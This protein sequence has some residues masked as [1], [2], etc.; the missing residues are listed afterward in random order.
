MTTETAEDARPP[1]SRII[2]AVPGH[3]TPADTPELLKDDKS[4]QPPEKLALIIDYMAPATFGVALDENEH[5]DVVR[6]RGAATVKGARKYYKTQGVRLVPMPDSVYVFLGID[7][8]TARAVPDSKTTPWGCH[9]AVKKGLTPFFVSCNVHAGSTVA[10][11]KARYWDAD[12]VFATLLVEAN[13]ERALAGKPPIAERVCLFRLHGFNPAEA[14]RRA[15]GRREQGP[16]WTHPCVR[17]GKAGGKAGGKT[18]A[19]QWKRL[20]AKETTKEL[21]EE[22]AADLAHRR[23]YS[24]R[25]GKAG[26]KATIADEVDAILTDAST[27][28]SYE[29]IY[30][31]VVQRGRARCASLDSLKFGM[32]Q[33]PR[34]RGWLRRGG[35]GRTPAQFRAP[36]D[37]SDERDADLCDRDGDASGD[38]SGEPAAAAAAAAREAPLAVAAAAR[39]APLAVAAAV[40]RDAPLAAAAAALDASGEP[41]AKFD[42]I[43]LCDSDGEAPVEP[44]AADAAGAGPRVPARGLHHLTLIP[45]PIMTK[46]EAKAFLDQR[47]VEYAKNATRDRLREMVNAEMKKEQ[48]ARKVNAKTTSI[49]DLFGRNQT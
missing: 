22:E 23:E 21:S 44:A 30:E 35:K 43:D 49:A 20:L 13:T 8:E 37:A 47:R 29:E 12:D 6:I 48:G 41:A 42:L 31:K 7:P 38:A 25:G 9:L 36:D 32:K 11:P 17:G 18:T 16:E 19:A 15:T 10:G 2:N 3:T 24:A 4:L 40:P 26:A 46:D 33:S 14:G 28:I 34:K 1:P 5:V 27:W 45:V 39:E